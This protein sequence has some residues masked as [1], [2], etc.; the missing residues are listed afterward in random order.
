MK[1]IICIFVCAVFLSIALTTP[2]SSVKIEN[3]ASVSSIKIASPLPDDIKYLEIG[4]YKQENEELIPV[5]RAEVYVYVY[6]NIIPQFGMTY[7]DGHLLFQPTVRVGDDV[8]IVAYHEWFGG[9]TTYL[10]ITE[11][12][13]EVISYDLV[14]DPSESVSKN[15]CEVTQLPYLMQK[16]QILSNLIKLK[17]NL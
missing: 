5:H 2:A 11:E 9:N 6:P 12:D 7:T 4:V 13:P 10:S 14:L 16:L 3:T 15:K 1:K 8:K 17:A